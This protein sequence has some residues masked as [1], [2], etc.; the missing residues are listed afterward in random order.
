MARADILNI[1]YAK[2]KNPLEFV[3]DSLWI[4]SMYN[5]LTPQ[6]IQQLNYIA[7]SARYNANIDKKY[8]M[9]D[10]I[11]VSRGFR[12]FHAGTNRVVYTHLEDPRFVAKIA[13]DKVG[14]TDNPNE[15][16]NQHLLKPFVTKVFEVSPCGTIAFVERIEPI[17]SIKE[18]AHIAG[19]VYDVLTECILGLYAL[20]DVGSDYFMNW[21]IRRGFGPCLLDFPYVFELDGNKLHC[22]AP[23]LDPITGVP[24]GVCDGEIDYD[25]GFNNLECTKCGKRYYARE[26]TKLHEQKL[27]ILKGESTMPLK[28]VIKRGDEIIGGNQQNSTDI[29]VKQPQ[30]VDYHN[31]QPKSKSRLKVTINWGDS[32]PTNTDDQEIDKTVSVEHKEEE[33]KGIESP[34]PTK[35]DTAEA[36][37]YAEAIIAEHEDPDIEEVSADANQQEDTSDVSEE[38]PETNSDL[39]RSVAETFLSR[40]DESVRNAFMNELNKKLSSD[41]EEEEEVSADANQQEDSSEEED[42]EP[43]L[44]DM[45]KIADMQV[46]NKQGRYKYYNK[47]KDKDKYNRKYKDEDLD[48]F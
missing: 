31:R 46:D 15:F 23:E 13:I 1:L 35:E 29:I 24:I 7:T 32:K 42:E 34:I 26:L 43:E 18:F 28:V 8:K 45:N 37:A 9:I 4:P 5:Y 3:F 30:V 17:T 16:K 47:K 6:D 19:D 27:I 2:D 10:E 25:V 44:D 38:N 21:G 48:N 22:N 40:E 41:E 39:A 20:E 12:K 33:I 36:I 14:I 11:M